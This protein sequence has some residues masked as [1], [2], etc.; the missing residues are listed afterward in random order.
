MAYWTTPSPRAAFIDR[1]ARL[2]AA[3]RTAG[4]PEVET[5]WLPAGYSRPRNFPHN[6]YRF[7]AESH[8]LYLIGRH[9]EGAVLSFHKDTWTLYALPPDPSD[10]LWTGPAPSLEE[11]E[12]ELGLPVRPL[13]ELQGGPEVALIPPQDADTAIWLAE[14]LDRDVVAGGGASLEGAA[15]TLAEALIAAR[16]RHDDAAIAQLRQAAAVTMEAHRAGFAATRPGLREAAVR[17]AMEL[18]ITAAGMVPSYNSIVT[19]HGEVLH[20]E[21]HH[22]EIE[23]GDL[24]LADVGAETAEGY[25]GDV[26]RTWPVSGVFSSTQRAAYEA[27]L[28][29]QRAAIAKVAPG[30]RYLEVHR[31]AG[32]A[33]LGALAELGLV[34]GDPEEA[35]AAGLS[36]LFFP[37]G[38]GHLL[39]LDVHDME[40]LGDRAGY[41]PGRS[42]L[43]GAGDRFLRLDRDLEPGMLVTIEPGFYQIPGL[44]SR[45]HAGALAPLV[46]W[47]ELERYAD[48]RGIRIE[49]DVLVTEHGHEVLTEQLP[50]DPAA[51][52]AC[53]RGHQVP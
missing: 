22:H 35:Y 10:A 13:A 37:H 25:A 16:L 7:R 45:E 38:I 24:L 28:I 51:V 43:P 3:L 6:R 44:T 46:N 53:V 5:A 20:S 1:R 29:A 39:G 33:L 8:F 21:R 9:L 41:A 4:G 27:V 2:A 30:V 11:L 47:A 32:R 52:E 48:V 15:I 19:V 34:N 17:A 12:V 31:A 49:D 36:A 42:R 26:T 23:A 14:Q 50:K 18:P 40:D